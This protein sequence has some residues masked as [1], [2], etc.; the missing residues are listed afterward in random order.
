M[1]YLVITLL[2]LFF[3]RH[4]FKSL[5]LPLMKNGT[6][7]TTFEMN[8][9]T[10]I[11]IISY[12][13]FHQFLRCPCMSRSGFESQS[14]KTSGIFKVSI[15]CYTGYRHSSIKTVINGSQNTVDI[16]GSITECQYKKINRG[17]Q[18]K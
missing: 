2:N 11:T 9:M 1:G 10:T 4:N 13:T 17:N 12:N 16:E 15:I 3:M 18:F 6:N 14:P 8:C 7:R 5:Y